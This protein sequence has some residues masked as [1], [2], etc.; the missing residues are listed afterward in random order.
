MWKSQI[1]YFSKYFDCQFAQIEFLICLKISFQCSFWQSR[2]HNLCRFSIQSCAGN[3]PFGQLICKRSCWKFATNTEQENK[4]TIETH[5]YTIFNQISFCMEFFKP[6]SFHFR[7]LLK[8]KE[9]PL[10][11]LYFNLVKS[12]KTFIILSE[13]LKFTFSI[14]AHHAHFYL[15]PQTFFKFCEIVSVTVFGSIK[16]SR[17]NAN[18]FARM[19]QNYTV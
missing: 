3:F 19:L 17:W 12:S 14:F 11:C 8:T 18:G 6:N 13:F 5:A 7:R 9:L 10:H 16:Q 15:V 1:F 2:H 4:K